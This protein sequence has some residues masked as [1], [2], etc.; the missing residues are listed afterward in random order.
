MSRAAIGDLI[1]RATRGGRVKNGKG[2]AK[3][4]ATVKVKAAKVKP[5][6]P[7]KTAHRPK[8]Q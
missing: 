5:A 1:G 2:Q 6:K 4:P 8:A 7:A 3:K